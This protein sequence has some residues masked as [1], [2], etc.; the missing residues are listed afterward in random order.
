MDLISYPTLHILDKLKGLSIEE[1]T[2]LAPVTGLK[3]Q[4][5]TLSFTEK[6]F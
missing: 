6:M 1:K 5:D 4:E 2:F 3:I